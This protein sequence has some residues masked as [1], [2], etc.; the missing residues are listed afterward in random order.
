[1]MSLFQT[2]MKEREL[3]KNVPSDAAPEDHHEGA[4]DFEVR[5]IT[6]ENQTISDGVDVPEPVP[7]ESID[8][9]DQAEEAEV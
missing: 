9:T 1:M 6:S 3:T 5:R 8:G 2:L 4:I 7:R